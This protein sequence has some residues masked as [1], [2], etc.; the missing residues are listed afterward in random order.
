MLRSHSTSSLSKVSIIYLTRRFFLSFR[1]LAV[2]GTA[3]Q[4][5]RRYISTSLSLFRS[6]SIVEGFQLSRLVALPPLFFFF[7]CPCLFFSPCLSVSFVRRRS[8]LITYCV[9]FPLIF[10]HFTWEAPASVLRITLRL[11]WKPWPSATCEFVF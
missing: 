3:V 2:T 5:R 4:F 8:S 11:T 6:I 9:G 10:H 7:F 1:A